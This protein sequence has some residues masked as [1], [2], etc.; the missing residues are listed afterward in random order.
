MK[1]K[2]TNKGKTFLDSLPEGKPLPTVV[3]L[4][5]VKPNPNLDKTLAYLQ[6]EADSGELLGI[7]Y[8]LQW[9]GDCVSSGYSLASMRARA[10]VGELTYL[11][12]EIVE[13]H[14]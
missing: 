13:K 8:V 12:Q 2:C 7:A 6:K 14:K 10:L 5:E 4:V 11:Q 9:K 1:G 3:K